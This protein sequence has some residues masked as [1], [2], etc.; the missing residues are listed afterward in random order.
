[1]RTSVIEALIPAQA[2]V[3]PLLREPRLPQQTLDKEIALWSSPENQVVLLHVFIGNFQIFSDSQLSAIKCL[4]PRLKIQQLTPKPLFNLG[5]VRLTT[6]QH[7]KKW[8]NEGV[9][10]LE[11]RASA[12]DLA[13]FSHPHP[14]FSEAIKEAALGATGDRVIH[15]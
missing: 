9:I 11:F 14:T 5:V 15:M 2:S 4:P 12:E 10:G 6:W 7:D 13:I 3:G 8:I 1:M